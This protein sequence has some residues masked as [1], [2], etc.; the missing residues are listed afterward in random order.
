MATPITWRNVEV[1]PVGEISRAMMS[2]Q[3][4]I[5]AGFESFANILKQ[6]QQVDDQN[7]NQQKSNNTNAFLNEMTKYTT[8][9]AYQAAL[10]SGELQSR[11]TASGA[12]IDQAAARQA[13]GA[14]MGILQ[15]RLT[16]G[17]QFQDAQTDRAEAAVKDQIGSLVAQGKTAEAKALLDQHTLRNEVKLYQGA[18]EA[19]RQA[20][21][22]GRADTTWKRSED[23]AAL[24]H[25][26]AVKT[27]QEDALTRSLSDAAARAQQAHRQEMEN[28]QVKVG[29]IAKELGLQTSTSGYARVDD[30]TEADLSKLHAGMKK[31]GIENP[32]VYLKG[33]TRAANDY[34]T[35]L[36]SSGKFP[37]HLIAKFKDGIRAGFDSTDPGSVGVEAADNRLAAAQNQVGYSQVADENWFTAGSPNAKKGY[38]Q[39]A[40]DVPNLID[41]TSG[42]DPH[43]DV[44]D[45]QKFVFE[46]ATKGIEVKDG[47]GKFITPPVQLVR[48]AV[49]TAQGGW[50]GDA[51]R[52]AA[53]RQVIVD[54]LNGIDIEKKLVEA[55]K[56]DAYFNKQ[57]VK[58]AAKLKE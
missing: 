58:E 39:L 26:E 22:Q 28:R 19:E 8:P 4:G 57:K 29:G 20:V 49:R 11:L 10:D 2:G 23:L 55:G 35:G 42:I 40:T 15:D 54:S 25:P 14:Q 1:N 52:A 7:W 47:S 37:A 30:M 16:K 51:Q 46:M 13:M 6:Q 45:M 12:Q 33:D 24:T 43:E 3:T 32:E 34:I 50:F 27:A 5:N 36:E 56:A 18:A 17:Q 21:I 31:A 9:E 38:E 41:K 44:A 48:N 53:A